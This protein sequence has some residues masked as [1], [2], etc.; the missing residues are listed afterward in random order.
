MFDPLG[1]GFV[2]LGFDGE[3]T[4]TL[5]VFDQVNSG[6]PLRPLFKRG[7]LLRVVPDS[8]RLRPPTI[9]GGDHGEKLIRHVS[10]TGLWMVVLKLSNLDKRFKFFYVRYK[11]TIFNLPKPS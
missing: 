6:E 5:R 4:G 11:S 9:A 7:L 10:L 1:N 2:L 8:Y 3:P